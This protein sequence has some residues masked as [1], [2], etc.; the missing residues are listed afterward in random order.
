MRTQPRSQSASVPP[1]H[2]YITLSS[3]PSSQ[4]PSATLPGCAA[5]ERQHQRCGVTEAQVQQAAGHGPDAAEPAGRCGHPAGA[6]ACLHH[7][8]G[9]LRHSALHCLLCLRSHGAG[10][11]GPAYC[12]GHWL[13]LGGKAPATVSADRLVIAWAVMPWILLC[14]NLTSGSCNTLQF[15]SLLFALSLWSL[16]LFEAVSC[17]VSVLT[18]LKLPILVCAAC[19]DF[20]E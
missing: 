3:A 15:Y 7:L 1:T 13:L 8:A 19:D 18:H 11:P 2:D 16:A 4:I 5:A 9:P 10:S 12:H 14:N 20:V 17:L 6:P